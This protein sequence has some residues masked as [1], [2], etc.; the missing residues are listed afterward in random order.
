MPPANIAN[1][2]LIP[3]QKAFNRFLVGFLVA[4]L[5]LAVGII[6]LSRATSTS[7][8]QIAPEMAKLDLTS[9][10]LDRLQG[11][12]LA[13]ASARHRSD[14]AAK[15]NFD[16]I[17]ELPFSEIR[18]IA[19]QLRQ[20]DADQGEIFRNHVN[21]LNHVAIN[22]LSLSW[23]LLEARELLL[24]SIN[25]VSLHAAQLA[26]QIDR[27]KSDALREGPEKLMAEAQRV[28]HLSSAAATT[29]DLHKLETAKEAL[30]EYGTL[31]ETLEAEVKAAGF[32]T[33]ELFRHADR[34]RSRLYRV[35]MQYHAS[36]LGVREA[37]AKFLAVKKDALALA[38]QQ[39]EG[40]FA[41]LAAAGVATEKDAIAANVALCVGLVWI[42]AVIS[43]AGLW[44]NREFVQ[45]VEDLAKFMRTM[46]SG[47]F[48]ADHGVR[49]RVDVVQSMVAS[50]ENFRSTM[51]EHLALESIRALERSHQALQKSDADRS[52]EFG[53][54]LRIV[55]E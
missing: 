20:V 13:L 43:L 22:S 26:E 7:V 52:N 16:A 18:T 27:L 54:R 34:P 4:N 30:T 23:R 31:L 36:T 49:A 32:A 29:S 42:I 51:R 11:V 37:D 55:A 48:W 5:L 25:D 2:P 47:N 3:I 9:Q 46:A 8:A 24:P 44:F 17:L 28:A 1:T 50:V 10:F 19:R 45:P 33:G 21:D 15:Q 41:A 39:R 12:Q 14:L 40:A 6:H 38:T 35:V 53:E